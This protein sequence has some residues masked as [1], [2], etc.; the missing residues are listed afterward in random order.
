MTGQLIAIVGPSGAGKDTLIGA[1]CRTRPDLVRVRRVITRA[2]DPGGEPFESVDR[3]EFENRRTNGAF[4][5]WWEAHGLMYGIPHSVQTDLFAGRTVLFNASRAA[6]PII[7]ERFPDLGV[8]AVTAPADTLAE[9][10]SSRGREASEDIQGRLARA[11]WPIPGEAH[12][13]INDG[14]VEDGQAAMMRAID[15]AIANANS[16]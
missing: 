2:A 15:A 14:S 4:V 8:I 11:D 9:R 1:A 6:L 3:A 10:L 12:V 13:V 5:F 7:M 16:E